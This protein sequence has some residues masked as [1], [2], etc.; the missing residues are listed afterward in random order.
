MFLR[1]RLTVAAVGIGVIAIPVFVFGGGGSTPVASPSHHAAPKGTASTSTVTPTTPVT[2]TTTVTTTTDP[3]TLPQTEAF[4]SASSPAFEARMASLWRGVAADSVES[5]L[6]AFFPESAYTQLKA[7][8][9][10]GG[11]YSERL[12][13]EYGQDIAA[14]HALLGPG[15]ALVGVQVD[16]GY[17]HWVPAGVCANSVGYFEVPNA[18]MVYSAGGQIASFGIASMISWRGEWYVVHLG[19]IL[20]SGAGGQ[21]DDPESGPGSSAYSG[22]C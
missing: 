1:R 4:P 3:G 10:A 22:T 8:P 5:A 13:V 7:I 19:A 2:T 11:D 9:D 15:A 20:R 21:V 6:P 16:S 14:A 17:G 18:R 12:V